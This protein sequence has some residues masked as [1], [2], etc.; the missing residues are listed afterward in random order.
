VEIKG[1]GEMKFEEMNKLAKQIQKAYFKLVINSNFGLPLHPPVLRVLVYL[2]ARDM[3]VS[4]KQDKIKTEATIAHEPVKVI[5]Q[6]DKIPRW[7]IFILDYLCG[8]GWVSPTQI[9][10]AWGPGYHSAWASP[11]C[12][13]LVKEGLLLRNR[14]GHYCLNSPQN[15]GMKNGKEGKNSYVC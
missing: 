15:K 1:G 10:K 8:E 3:L 11:Y 7:K 4:T 13:K 2:N 9:G 14:R 5:K 6:C 12:K